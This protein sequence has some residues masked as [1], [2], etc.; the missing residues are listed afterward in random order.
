M[1]FSIPF[2]VGDHELLKENLLNVTGKLCIKAEH[3]EVEINTVVSEQ[4]GHDL[5]RGIVQAALHVVD[6][7]APVG[8]KNGNCHFVLSQSGHQPRG[9]KADRAGCKIGF[10]GMRK[11]QLCSGIHTE[12]IAVI[13][14]S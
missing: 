9:R 10:V 11:A 7:R 3:H 4:P 12:F 1:F 14:F 8:A 13:H 6:L 2:I 5:P